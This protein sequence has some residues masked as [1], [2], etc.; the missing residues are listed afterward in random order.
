M[1]LGFPPGLHRCMVYK[2]SYTRAQS[3]SAHIG[4][5]FNVSTFTPSPKA[6]SSGPKHE[7]VGPLIIGNMLNRNLIKAQYAFPRR[8]C[9]FNV[10]TV[11]AQPP[12]AL[13][14]R[15]ASLRAPGP[16]VASCQP[17]EGRCPEGVLTSAARRF[18]SRQTSKQHPGG[19]GLQGT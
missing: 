10:T 6:S 11:E 5:L 13:L 8:G 1:F 3:S 14:L 18:S 16:V 17:F 2:W 4:Y 15:C 7:A 12:R 9:F 19:V